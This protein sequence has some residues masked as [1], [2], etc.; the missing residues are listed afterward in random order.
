MSKTVK[1][2][3]D[4][5]LDSLNDLVKDDGLTILNIA[6]IVVSLMKIAEK[7]P[8]VPGSQR[9]KLIMEVLVRFKTEHPDCTID[10][11][12]VASMIDVMVSIDKGELSIHEV[13]S[14]LGSCFT[15]MTN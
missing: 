12:L 11:G 1:D 15:C 5:L 4:T 7:F 8:N 2:F 3:S 13:K 6:S 9:K 10:L 14:C